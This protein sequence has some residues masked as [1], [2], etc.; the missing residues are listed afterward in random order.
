VRKDLALE[1]GGLAG[2]RI[3]SAGQVEPRCELLRALA[4]GQ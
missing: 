4:E 3:D 2:G 1:F